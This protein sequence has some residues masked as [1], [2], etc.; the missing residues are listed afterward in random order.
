[1]LAVA[2][3]YSGAVAARVLCAC[4]MMIC[5]H[6]DAILLIY[7]DYAHA[8]ALLR[9]ASARRYADYFHVAIWLQRIRHAA[10]F[11]AFVCHAAHHMLL[12]RHGA[13]AH[14][15]CRY[16]TFAIERDVFSPC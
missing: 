2:C 7:A 13:A 16:A 12:Q 11:R 14:D 8:A 5:C 3:R 9:F 4:H 1:M 15:A 6:A 10:P